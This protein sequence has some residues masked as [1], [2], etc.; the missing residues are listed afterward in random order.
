MK[1][2]ILVV[3]DDRAMSAG[4]CLNLREAGYEPY[5]VFTVAE[6]KQ[7]CFGGGMG[8]NYALVILDVG[9]PDGS[10][11]E[12]AKEIRG[13][14]GIPLI[15]LTAC[16]LDTDVMRGF[17]AGADDYITKPFHVGVLFCRIR[18]L[19]RR[20]ADS[21]SKKES[22]EQVKGDLLSVGNLEIDYHGYQV[23]KRGKIVNLTPT[24]F[25]LLF[26]LSRNPGRV[27]TRKMLLDE[28]WDVKGNYVDEHALTVQMSRLKQ[29]IAD[30]EFSYI[31]TVYGMGYQWIGEEDE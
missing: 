15:M 10:G 5:P 21:G 18:A 14:C 28:V 8:E 7:A 19:L 23:K 3:E 31:K 1:E 16:D 4:L 24:E 2:R 12:L 9:L 25:D 13:A 20:S 17:E 26:R 29:K 11:L 6:A 30:E 27:I 22:R